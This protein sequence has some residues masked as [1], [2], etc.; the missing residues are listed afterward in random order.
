MIPTL[1]FANVPA[2]SI[3]TVNNE[4]IVIFNKVEI[5]KDKI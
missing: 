4:S 3:S 5:F 2:F 1:L